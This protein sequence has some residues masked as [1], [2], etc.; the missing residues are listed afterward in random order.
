MI[1]AEGAP[2]ETMV[3]DAL[4]ARKLSIHRSG[5]VLS[6]LRSAVSPWID[7]R[8]PGDG[9]WERLAERAESQTGL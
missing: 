3:G 5:V 7:V 4:F 9:I 6:R 8:R 1:F 2:T